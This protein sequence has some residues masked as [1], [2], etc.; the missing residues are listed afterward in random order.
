MGREDVGLE[1]ERVKTGKEMEGR[2]RRFRRG[3][4]RRESEREDGRGEGRLDDAVRLAASFLSARGF[5]VY[6]IWTV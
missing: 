2:S 3:K 5:S 1:F 6:V 4:R